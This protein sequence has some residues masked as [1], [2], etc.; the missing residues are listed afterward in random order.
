MEQWNVFSTNFCYCLTNDRV[1]NVFQPMWNDA[2]SLHIFSSKLTLSSRKKWPRK[3]WDISSIKS[4]RWGTR[5]NPARG[6]PCLVNH[7]TPH[8]KLHP[9]TN[10]ELSPRL[11]A[12]Q[13]FIRP[14]NT[15]VWTEI[16]WGWKFS[17]QSQ[18][19]PYISRVKSGTKTKVS[20]FSRTAACTA[21]DFFCIN[22][23]FHAGHFMWM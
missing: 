18:I 4:E 9:G 17:C 23:S 5:L 6:P 21:W 2:T 3:A 8:Y 19:S 16:S 14:P 7:W 22:P 1:M 20:K 13:T 10:D 11:S 15:E 12:G